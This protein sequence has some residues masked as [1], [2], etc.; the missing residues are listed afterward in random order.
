M[1][2]LRKIKGL[3]AVG[4]MISILVVLIASNA[5]AGGKGSGGRVYVKG[6]FKKDGTYVSPHYR[7]APDGN[8]YNNYSYPGNYNP[9]TGN[10]TPGNPE[11][12]LENYYKKKSGDKV[13]P[14]VNHESTNSPAFNNNSQATTANSTTTKQYN[15]TNPPARNK[16]EDYDEIIEK[17]FRPHAE[18]NPW[19]W[20]KVNATAD[21]SDTAYRIGLARKSIDDSEGEKAIQKTLAEDNRMYQEML[22]Q[23]RGK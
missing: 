16:Y 11:T 23:L 3:F 22:K 13:Y 18:K 5:Y 2:I 19:V 10:I 1:F 4:A 21:P 6:Y 20:D 14:Y 12:Y 15:Y 9:N 7:T 8:P 17:Y